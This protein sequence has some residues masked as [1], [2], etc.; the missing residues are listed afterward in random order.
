MHKYT[1]I[2]EGHISWSPPWGCTP[3]AS[4]L[5]HLLIYGITKFKGSAHLSPSTSLSC[6]L[7]TRMCIAHSEV[8]AKN[9]LAC[10]QCKLLYLGLSLAVLGLSRISRYQIIPQQHDRNATGWVYAWFFWLGR[11]NSW[12]TRRSSWLQLRRWLAHTT[13]SDMQENS[14]GFFFCKY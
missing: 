1:T 12:P 14:I 7:W 8:A 6:Q 9:S 4:T 13:N 11:L 5:E 3:Q 10:C 2:K